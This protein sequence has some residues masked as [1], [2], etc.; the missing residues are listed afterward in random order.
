VWTVIGLMKNH[1]KNSREIDHDAPEERVEVAL[2]EGELFLFA[3]V[4]DH[5][6]KVLRA[7]LSAKIYANSEAVTIT[8]NRRD[9][10]EAQ[11][12]IE[13][14]LNI[15]RQRGEID[16]EDVETVLR[17]MSNRDSLDERE[18]PSGFS[19]I[20]TPQKK[21]YLRSANQE[22]YYQATRSNDIVFVI[23]PAGTGKTY[24]A[25]AMAVEALTR[26]QIKRIILCRPAVE[27]GENL[28][29]LPGDLKEKV[30]PYFRPLYDALM[31]MIPAERLKRM[32]ERNSIEIA[33]LAY[34]RGRT[35]S[36]AFVILDEAQNSTAD[37]MMMFLTRLGARSKALITGDK[38]QIDLPKK[39][40]SGLLQ[41][42]KVLKDIPGIAFVTLTDA[43][44]VRHELVKRIITA[45]QDFRRDGDK[46]AQ[47]E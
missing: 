13:E 46:H 24:L 10:A 42:P 1:R 30:D 19:K 44:A 4:Q 33:P 26:H 40:E 47:D 7:C 39:E 3:G 12:V 45:Y 11:N 6:L 38:T 17:L 32:I 43:D 16:D 27:A 5:N 41:A 8:G 31:E 15:V 29:F 2:R 14:L 34:M 28:G 23:G 18:I 36:D 37:Q 9:V 25:V 35:L 21:I 22:N 20:E